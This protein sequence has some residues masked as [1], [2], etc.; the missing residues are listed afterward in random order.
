M[1]H[2][3]G[4]PLI[5][6]VMARNGGNM[7]PA[8]VVGPYEEAL[9]LLKGVGNTALVIVRKTRETFYAPSW[10]PEYS[11]TD[12]YAGRITDAEPII[13]VPAGSWNIATDGHV[14]MNWLVGKINK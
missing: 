11:T 2:A 13:D 3:P 5:N 9:E 10:L 1:A 12:L 6:L 7:P 8:E 14:H 4:A